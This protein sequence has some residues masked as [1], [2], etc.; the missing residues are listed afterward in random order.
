MFSF[1]VCNFVSDVP[2][3]GLG[4]MTHGQRRP[5]KR[6]VAPVAKVLKFMG[7]KDLKHIGETV[8]PLKRRLEWEDDSCFKSPRVAGETAAGGRKKG[9]TDEWVA[10]EDV[11]KQ[12]HHYNK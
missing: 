12:I 9:G 2:L 10:V 3:K 8:F 5:N 7:K 1:F 11:L 6:K 4:S